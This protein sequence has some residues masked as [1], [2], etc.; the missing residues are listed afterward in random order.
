[1]T[2]T[3]DDPI[4]LLKLPIERTKTNFNVKETYQI[5]STVKSSNSTGFDDVKFTLL[6]IV[7]HMMSIHHKDFKVSSGDDDHKN[8]TSMQ[9]K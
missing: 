2:K 5:I 7:S 4:W 8:I 3:K 6:K 1:M 9:A